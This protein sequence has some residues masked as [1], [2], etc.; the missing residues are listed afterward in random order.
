MSRKSGDE[1]V[2][3]NIMVE[4]PNGDLPHIV[5]EDDGEGNPVRFLTREEA[6]KH[7][8]EWTWADNRG[9]RYTVVP[10]PQRKEPR[11]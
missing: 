3:F 2:A 11:Q 9:W 1:E 5:R 10:A 6:Q 4:V 8:D 7:A